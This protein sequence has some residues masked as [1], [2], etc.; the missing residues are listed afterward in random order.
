[1]RTRSTRPP[2]KRAQQPRLVVPIVPVLLGVVGVLGAA[3]G[4]TFDSSRT[5]PPRG[6]LGEELY[7]VVCDRLGAQSLHEDL[8]GASY[9]GICHP[10]A[11]GTFSSTVDESSLPPLVDGQANIDGKP[12]PLAKQ[13]TE[14]AYGVARLQTLAA[15]R[16]NLVAALDATFP[17]VQVP[18]TDVGNT[19]PTRSCDAPATN[20]EGSLH[21]EL[22]NLLG[23]L[24]GLYDDGTIPQSTE[25]MGRVM[26]AFEA[27]TNAQAAWGHFD[28]RAGYRPITLALGAARPTI[29][30]PYLRDFTNATLSLLSPDSEPYA[31]NPQL[32]AAGNR[33]AVPGPA[34]P[35][36]SRM[37]TVAYAEL[38]NA[39]PDVPLVPLTLTT[40]ATTGATVLSRPRSDLEL[41]Q[42]V[43]YAQDAAFGAGAPQYIVQR[44][45]R[46]YAAVPLVEGQVPPPFVDQDGD[47]LPDLDASGRFV[48]TTGAPAPS[49]FFAMGAPDAAARDAFSRALNAP[50]GTPLYAYIDTTHTYAASLMHDFEPLLDPS[51][52]D[53]HETLMNLLAG[54]YVLSGTRDGSA[55]S[56]RTYADGETVFYDAFDTASSP[57]IDLVYAF[58]QILADPTADSTLS[59]ASALVSQQP[60]AV[61]RMVG[62]GLYSKG[63]A[64][65]DHAAHIPSTSTLWDDL[66]DVGV[67][68][69]AE[70]GLLAD[71]LRALGDDASL[72]LS[73]CFS[74]YAQNRDRISYDRSRLNGPAFDFDTGDT[75][76]PTTAVDRAQADSGANRSEMQ[77]F[78][79]VIRDTDGVTACNKQGAVV[80][81]QGVT[82]LGSVD[83]PSGPADGL[84]ASLV[85]DVAYGSKSTFGECEVFKID[86]LAAFYLD[87]IVGSASMYFRDNFIRNGSIGSIGAATVG[88]IEQS[89]GLGYDGTSGGDTYNGGDLGGPGFWDTSGSQ[90]F[91]PKPGWLNRLVFFDIA[92]DSP[93][94]AG[95][96]YTTNHFLADLQGSDIGTSICPERL[97][98]DPCAASANSPTCNGAPD[99]ASDGMVHGL[100]ACPDGDWLFQRDQDATFVWE[101][102]GFYQ[103]ITPLLSA[104]AV[105]DNPTTGQPRHREDLFVALIEAL[106]AHWQSAQGTADECTLQIDPAV[107]CARDGADTYEPLLAKI[108]ASDTL[109]AL[110]DLVHVLEGLSVPTCAATDSVTHQCTSAGPVQDGVT[111]LAGAV[112]A[113][114]NPARA[115]LQGLRDRQG[116]VTSPRN[117]GTTNPQVTPLYLVLE[118]LDA[119]DR[120]FAQYAQ[121]NPQDTA[122]QARWTLARSQLVDQF[123][124]VRGENTPMQSF[125]DPSL[126][127]ILPVLLD[128]TRSQRGSQCPSPTNAPGGTCAWAST[129]LSSSAVATVGGP[130]FAA[131]MDLVDAIGQNQ[132]ARG[133][134]EQLLTYLLDAGSSNDALPELLA[135]TDDLIQVLGDDANLVPFYRI[136]ASALAPA[137]AD[138]QG[139]AQ[140]GMVDALTALLTRLAGRAYDVS[141]TEICAKELDPDAV[142]DFALAHLATPMT[143]SHGEPTETPLEVIVDTIA[144]VNR[145]SPGSTTPLAPPDYAN[146]ANELSAFLLDDQRGLEQLYQVM[147]NGSA[148]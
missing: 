134:T 84:A 80:H 46:G 131:S 83:L 37:T 119:I 39:T 27:A 112:D 13:Q 106:N 86:D 147:R 20:S 98:P 30:Y 19:D 133:A 64:D 136:A 11:D 53:D 111:V 108:F 116:N 128:A 3:C 67:Q 102:Y 77:R 1:M 41:L 127:R 51:P 9:A 142:L 137:V 104:F 12:V 25:S 57:L 74:G 22:S 126:P 48:T 17:D 103:A 100:R 4:D 105:A 82:L 55:K 92:G 76:A 109:P 78:L 145:A 28:A 71:I 141:H 69:D 139:N 6:T 91:R 143:P 138:A 124:G 42:T 122:R 70:P 94:S 65:Q 117:D 24:Q 96:N 54:A 47:G 33:I 140:R 88:L 120:A 18:I 16:T 107:S 21:T 26:E 97:I 90:T 73:T 101:D 29:A 87:S 66:I 81:A 125:V 135:S 8:S 38:V 115:R 50:G 113:L 63:L 10:R 146:M 118:T 75:S 130:A 35:Q 121:L 34:Y 85:L 89:S 68:I 43:F 60:N 45:R 58:G 93:T 110:H 148:P 99:V 144:D 56:T 132:P 52:A 32:D 95:P 61:A 31:L 5:L 36:L 2:G 79:Q 23:R 129:T 40:D 72:G 49:P 15:D 62:D 59:L 114:V 7:G 44:D 123:L 14:R